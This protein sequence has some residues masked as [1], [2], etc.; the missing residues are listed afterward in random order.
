MAARA[1]SVVRR[2]LLYVPSSSPK[3]LDKSR[4]LTVDTVCYDLEDSVTPTK[5]DEARHN[6]RG[7]LEQ[8][9]QASGIRETAVRINAV[10]SGL[11]LKDLNEIVSRTLSL[12]PSAAS[13]FTLV[14]TISL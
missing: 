1:A 3:F 6:L 5:K 4:G 10:E 14:S 8:G 9:K 12:A 13:L 7:F 11:A 2:A